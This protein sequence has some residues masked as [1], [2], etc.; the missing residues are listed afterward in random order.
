MKLHRHWVA[1]TVCLSAMLTNGI[2]ALAQEKAPEVRAKTE[3]RIVIERDGPLTPGQEPGGPTHQFHYSVGGGQEDTFVFVSSEM[4][5]G[6]KVVKGA[7]YSAQASTE[8]VQ[9]LADGN[10]IVRKSTG[11][12]YRDGEGRTRTEQQLG[13]IGP[14]AASGDPPQ[15]IIINDPVA[16]VNYVLDLRNTTARKVTM[17]PPRPPVEVA[18]GEPR[19][20]RPPREAPPGVGWTEVRSFVHQASDNAKTESLGK[21]VVEGIEAEGTRI[22]HTIPA[23][24]IG[25]ELPIQITGE[26]WYSPELQVVVMSKHSDP[27]FGE[28]TY[29]LTN[30]SRTEPSPSLFAPPADYTIKEG[31]GMMMRRPAPPRREM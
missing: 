25:N 27:R 28:T 6:G 8:S 30:I 5:F 13:A 12:V 17:G 20:V 14:F 21:R 1:S 16:G 2:A 22:T 4:G 3:R 29:R 18:G 26:R 11:A 9:T 19:R 23:G 31:P 10:R 15:T 7:P 24:E